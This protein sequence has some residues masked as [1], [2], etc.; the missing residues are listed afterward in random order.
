MDRPDRSFHGRLSPV[1]AALAVL[2][3]ALPFVLGW[4]EG[5]AAW[6]TG[7]VVGLVLLVVPGGT[8]HRGTGLVASALTLPLLLSLGLAVRAA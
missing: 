1:G 8:R 6:V 2:L 4:A 7:P 5:P 3:V